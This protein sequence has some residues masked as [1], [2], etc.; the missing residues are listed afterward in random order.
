[1]AQYQIQPGIPKKLVDV[2][3][4]GAGVNSIAFGVP[5]TPHKGP[6]T[7]T[8]RTAYTGPPSAVNVVLQGAIN[9]VD[10]EYFTLDTSTATA[11]ETRA[12][13]NANIR[14]IRARLVSHT[15]A[16]SWTVEVY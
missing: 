3:G 1:M 2:G 6:R 10:A 11:G 4:V 14:F 15:G 9:D 16:T 12:V 13:N 8:W 7:I 5:Q